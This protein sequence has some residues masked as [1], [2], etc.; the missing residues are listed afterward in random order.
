M[1]AIVARTSS[2]LSNAKTLGFY[3][4][5]YFRKLVTTSGFVKTCRM[6]RPRF[7]LEPKSC[8]C[9]DFAAHGCAMGEN[10]GAGLRCLT[11]PP[12]VFGGGPTPLSDGP[13]AY[14]PF[15]APPRWPR[16]G[17]W[18]SQSFLLFLPLPAFQMMG[19]IIYLWMFFL[20]TFSLFLSWK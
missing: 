1:Q 14:P 5:T 16:R 3:E 17:K 11:P 6:K 2:F 15:W 19:L 12:E 20:I 18:H 9:S 13:G 10:P 4:K 7:S 8:L